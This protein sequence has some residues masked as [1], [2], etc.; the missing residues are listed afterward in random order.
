MALG[1]VDGDGLDEIVVGY[2][3][4]GDG[5]IRILD[6]HTAGY[7]HL[8]WIQVGWSAYNTANGEVWPVLAVRLMEMVLMKL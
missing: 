6:D 7:A 3:Y 5:W 8:A 4:I 2:G 1:D